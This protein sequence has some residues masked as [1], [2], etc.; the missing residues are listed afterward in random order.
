MTPRTVSPAL[1]FAVAALGI[2]LFSMM[3]AVMKSL[4]LAIGVYNALLWRQMVS[5]GLGAVAWR[6]GK[7]GR[8]SAR[9]LKLHC[10]RGL[11]TTAMAVLFFWG[12]ARVPMAQAISLTYIAPILA[13][14]LAAV[15]LGERV[16]WKTVVASIVALGGVVVVMIGQ[17][18]EVPGPETLLGTL[19][20]L[21]SAV[22]YAVNLVIARLQSQAARPG[23]IAFF[24]ALVITATLALAAPWLAV[25]PEAASWPKLVLAAGLA[26]ASLWL[27]GWAYAHG[28][29]GFLATTE[30]TSFVYAAGLGFLV[31]GERVSAFTLAGAAVIVVACLYAARRRDIAQ[32]SIEATV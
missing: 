10:A 23:E 17:G 5:V 25:V 22:L 8:P 13:L 24:Q 1:A 12:L 6:L 11:V 18:R 27:L 30:Y 4:V 3:D 14:L 28:D 9:A 20:I 26:T 29:T 7:S 15:T 2:G 31:F 16:G 21:G 32:T 19:S